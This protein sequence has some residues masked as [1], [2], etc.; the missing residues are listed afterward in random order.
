MLSLARH[1]F[2]TS[3][4]TAS[5]ASLAFGRLTQTGIHGFVRDPSGAVIPGATVKAQ[6]TST[7][8]ERQTTSAADG[9]FVFP[10]LVA[11]TYNVTAIGADC[12]VAQL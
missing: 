1:F 4:L 11:G 8:I 2:F 10:N 3:C 7:T 6:D 9:G 12:P 5:L